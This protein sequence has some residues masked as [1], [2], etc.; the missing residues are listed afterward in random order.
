MKIVLLVKKKTFNLLEERENS[1]LSFYRAPLIAITFY[2]E[3]FEIE[4]ILSTKRNSPDAVVESS[5]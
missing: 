4:V 1:I 2:I 3:A 5:K